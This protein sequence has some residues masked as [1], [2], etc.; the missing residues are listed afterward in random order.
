MYKVI[1]TKSTRKLKLISIT[2]NR[3]ESI[4]RNENV[5]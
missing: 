3:T 4:N 1:E 2:I 5:S